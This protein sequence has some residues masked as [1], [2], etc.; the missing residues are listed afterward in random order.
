M[1]KIIALD[2][3]LKRT[4]VAMTDELNIIA[5]PLPTVESKD[6]MKFL[7]ELI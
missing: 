6:L 3:G 5:L 2:F 4:G 1:S 7:I